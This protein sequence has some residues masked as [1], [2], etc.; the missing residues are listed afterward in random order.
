MNTSNAIDHLC[1]AQIAKDTGHTQSVV[2]VKLIIL[3][4]EF[5]HRLQG[6]EGRVIQVF[7][8]AEGQPARRGVR[9]RGLLVQFRM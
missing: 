1:D 7:G 6:D 4:Q 5:D 2:A 9:P 8:Q 3:D